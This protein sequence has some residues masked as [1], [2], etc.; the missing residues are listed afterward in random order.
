MELVEKLEQRIDEVLSSLSSLREENKR[1]K[2]EASR[3][4]SL[5][6]EENAR[7]KQELERERAAKSAVLNRVDALLNKIHDATSES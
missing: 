2:D 5:L 6:E 7:L 3:G 4:R 1:L